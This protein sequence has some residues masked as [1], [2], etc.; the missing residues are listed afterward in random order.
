MKKIA[1]AALMWFVRLTW[2]LLDTI[3]G[4]FIFLFFVA[5]NRVNGIDIVANTIV[6]QVDRAPNE[7]GWGLSSGIFIFSNTD[8][9]WNRDHLLF[10]EW[11]HSWPQ[12][13]IFGP[14]HLFVV[15]IPSV[16]RFQYRNM[17]IRKGKGDNL[18]DYD[19]AWF[20]GTASRWGRKWFLW[21]VENG[22]WA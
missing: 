14:L 7:G 13:V 19:A 15:F 11:G 9:I 20:E 16:L 18:P 3:V 10:H 1:Y 21:G 6:V 5:T 17:L 8:T 12:I 4:I 22:L 2:G